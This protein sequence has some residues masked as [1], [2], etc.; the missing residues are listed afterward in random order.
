MAPFALVTGAAD[1]IGKG[2]ALALAK[3]GYDIFLHYNSSI[4]KAKNTQHLIE[5]TG[6]KC[7]LKKADFRVEEEV[8]SLIENCAKE[9][10]LEVLINNASVFVESDIEMEGS[11]LLDELFQT[12]FKAPYILT[13]QFARH[14]RKGL[15]VNILDTKINQHH[16]KHL[17]Y[18]LSKKNLE[19]FTY[20][21]ATQLA[22]SIRVNGIAPGLILPPENKSEN[23]LQKLAKNIPLQQT[24]SV[25][26]LAQ[27]MQFLIE[28][29][30]I[31]GEIIHVD[32][33][34]HL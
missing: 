32:G 27:A 22:P 11:G 20:L 17:D 34:E 6:R 21:S 16:T 24:G 29:R 7:M 9:G 30:F 4:K 12:N 23:Y 31:T 3:L 15:I 19:A 18:L 8:C 33:G 28:N 1:R 5:Q 14:C 25:K 26:Q 2:L 13:K 10:T